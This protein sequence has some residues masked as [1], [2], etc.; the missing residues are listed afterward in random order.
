MPAKTP[1]T[2]VERKLVYESNRIVPQ[3]NSQDPAYAS[4][5][6]VTKVTVTLERDGSFINEGYSIS[7]GGCYNRIKLGQ[8]SDNDLEKAMNK[9]EQMVK[10]EAAKESSLDLIDQPR[11]TIK[12]PNADC[13]LLSYNY[14]PEKHVYVVTFIQDKPGQDHDPTQLDT[15]VYKPSADNSRMEYRVLTEEEDAEETSKL[16]LED[17]KDASKPSKEK[18]ARH[19]PSDSFLRYLI[20]RQKRFL[21]KKDE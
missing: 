19:D 7:Q 3:E 6:N 14:D 17:I 9:A 8:A 12:T 2:N 11:G 1:G 21:K 20:E 16:I 5:M 13:F 4:W 18:I 15:G 10:D